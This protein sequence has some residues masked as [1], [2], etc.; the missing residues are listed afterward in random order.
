MKLP[1]I[2]CFFVFFNKKVKKQPSIKLG[3]QEFRQI[4]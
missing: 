2:S 1:Q 3:N 4:N